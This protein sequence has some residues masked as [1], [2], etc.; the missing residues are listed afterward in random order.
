MKA[1]CSVGSREAGGG[2]VWKGHATVLLGIPALCPHG[3]V[4][5]GWTESRRKYSK[6]EQ[7]RLKTFGEKVF[8]YRAAS[9]IGDVNL[10]PSAGDDFNW[11]SLKEIPEYIKDE[12]LVS[13]FNR[14]LE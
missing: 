12:N 10:I 14:V 8:Y 2:D 4:Y 5:S 1:G 7:S 13:L 9:L 11:V 3:V 6:E